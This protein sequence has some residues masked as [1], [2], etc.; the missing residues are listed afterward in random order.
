V[1]KA[2]EAKK[3]PGNYDKSTGAIIGASRPDRRTD[4][5]VY[6]VG[7]AKLEMTAF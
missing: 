6:G 5:V 4:S 7:A 3:K 1:V 2:E